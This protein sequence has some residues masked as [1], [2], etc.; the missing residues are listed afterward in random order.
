[1]SGFLVTTVDKFT[2][3]VA[4]DRYYTTDG[5]WAQADGNR[6]RVGLSD[7]LQQRNGDIAFADLLPQGTILDVGDEFASLETIKVN[8]SL[9]SPVSGK[10]IE[11]NSEM[12]T[13]PEVINQD[14]YSAGW[15]AVIE[16]SDWEADR[17]GLL[18]PPAYFAQMKVE[19][20]RET[21]K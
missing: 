3:K 6:V 17:A 1:M 7:Y 19:A 13:A 4:A 12:A 20:E 8:L 5:V 16:A 9:A 14:P 2:F 15:L 18:D 10:I 11:I 21:K